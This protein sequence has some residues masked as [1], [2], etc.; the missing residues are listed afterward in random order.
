MLR[1]F[2]DIL[3]FLSV[4]LLP[5]WVTLSVAVLGMTLFSRFVEV[6]AVGFLLD[7]LFGI[8]LHL[9]G[10]FQFTFASVFSVLFFLGLFLSGA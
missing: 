8:P 7:L 4:L 2:F 3:L 6:I 10:G 5:W 9:F 1:I